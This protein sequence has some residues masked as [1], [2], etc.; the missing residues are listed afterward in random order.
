MQVVSR[1][2]LGRCR[3]LKAR[4]YYRQEEVDRKQ[5]LHYHHEAEEVRRL[6]KV[7]HCKEAQVLSLL[8]LP[9]QKY[10]Y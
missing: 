6:I 3:R 4:K 8:A 7:R 10:K 1:R 9:V 5:I 2:S